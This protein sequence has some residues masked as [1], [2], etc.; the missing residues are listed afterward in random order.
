MSST[1]WTDREVDASVENMLKYNIARQ[2]LMGNLID[3]NP[4]TGR[5][6]WKS[7]SNLQVVNGLGG[8]QFSDH[9]IHGNTFSIRVVNQANPWKM[10]AELGY[11][12]GLVMASQLKEEPSDSPY[13]VSAEFVGRALAWYSVSHT[14]ELTPG[15]VAGD[16]EANRKHAMLSQAAVMNHVVRHGVP[17][18]REKLRRLD[19]NDPYGQLILLANEAYEDMR[20]THRKIFV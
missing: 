19:R 13:N 16:T 7:P 10:I 5:M 17:I 12:L 15:Y 1:T 8:M 18:Y 4:M 3:S 14:S 20:R 2:G 9:R 6:D 11:R